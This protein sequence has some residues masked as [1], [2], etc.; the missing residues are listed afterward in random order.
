MQKDTP[1]NARS[2]QQQKRCRFNEECA[3]NHL[4]S[5]YYGEWNELKD[6][7]KIV[8]NM[9]ADSSSKLEKFEQLE[10]VAKALSR[11]VSSLEK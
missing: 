7:V 10:N 2:L 6:K 11:K 1:L 3:Y 4:V 9:V 8:E 5:K